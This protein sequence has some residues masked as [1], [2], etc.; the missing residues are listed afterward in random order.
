M[1]PLAI[2]TIATAV[3]FILGC[4]LG[5]LARRIRNTKGRIAVNLAAAV[6]L[7]LYCILCHYIENQY[8]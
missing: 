2:G 4:L 6:L 3:T 7:I 1:N 5:Q 8:D